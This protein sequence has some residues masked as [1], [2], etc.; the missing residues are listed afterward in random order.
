MI[1]SHADKLMIS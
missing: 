1:K